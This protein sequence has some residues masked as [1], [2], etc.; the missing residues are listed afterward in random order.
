MFPEVSN[1]AGFD[2]LLVK[3]YSI[4]KI[5]EILETFKKKQ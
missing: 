4:H 3:P 1:H 5:A 2:G